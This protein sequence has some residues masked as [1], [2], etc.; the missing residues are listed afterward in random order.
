[1]KPRCDVWSK[2]EDFRFKLRNA[3]REDD[4]TRVSQQFHDHVQLAQ[5]ER[6]YYQ[7]AIKKSEVELLVAQ[8]AQKPRHYVYYTFD[9]A[10]QVFI[11]HHARQVVPIYFKVC[12][13][14]QLFGVCYDGNRKQVLYVINEDQSIGHNRTKTHCLN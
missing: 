1:M 5:Q 12:R 2:C 9:F 14:I 8:E 4:K 6:D 7:S 13:K 10:E 3:F 11:P